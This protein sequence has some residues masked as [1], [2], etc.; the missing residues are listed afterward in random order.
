MRLN[1]GVSHN[2]ICEYSDSK[3]SD[4]EN[5]MKSLMSWKLVYKSEIF[6]WNIDGRNWASTH[7]EEVSISGRFNS[8]TTFWNFQDRDP[9]LRK[10]TFLNLILSPPPKCKIFDGDLDW[11]KPNEWLLRDM[12]LTIEMNQKY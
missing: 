5:G 9:R 10:K 6:H 11:E 4:A 2:K 7:G 12:S 8:E 1:I 3:D